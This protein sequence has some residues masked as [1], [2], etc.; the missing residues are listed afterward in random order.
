MHVSVYLCVNVSVHVSYVCKYI[1]VS[2]HVYVCGVPNTKFMS[3]AC[4]A[5]E[6]K[7]AK[8]K[9]GIYI[10]LCVFVFLCVWCTIYKLSIFGLFA[11]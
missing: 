2:V 9:T 4:M 10:C 3:L 6:P 11:K 5:N 7:S 8:C 1:C